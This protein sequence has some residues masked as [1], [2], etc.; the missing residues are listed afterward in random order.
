MVQVS[1]GDNAET[2]II[3]GKSRKKRYYKFL[4]FAY[5]TDVALKLVPIEAPLKV[6]GNQTVLLNPDGTTQSIIK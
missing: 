2:T 4:R 3:T 5:C 1:A 6:T